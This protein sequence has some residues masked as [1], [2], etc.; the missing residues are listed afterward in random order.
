MKKFL[1]LLCCLVC[2]FS[3]VCFSACD[4]ATDE[5]TVT[6][7]EESTSDSSTDT[8]DSLI[9]LSSD[10]EEAAPGEEFVITCTVKESKL[11]AAGDLTFSFDKEQLTAEFVEENVKSM[12]SFSNEIAAGYQY[13]A[14][15]ANTIDMENT[16]LFT[17]YCVVSEDCK[18]GEEIKIDLSCDEWLVGLDEKGDDIKS[19]AADMT[20]NSLLIKVK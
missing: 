5:T 11:F 2:I 16:V 18:S 7:T 15:V 10:L 4:S 19:I 8:A 17:V 12:Y 3:L 13:S 14:Y 9:T 6:N 20:T 1:L